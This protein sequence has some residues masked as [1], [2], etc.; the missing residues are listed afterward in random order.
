MD[1]AG[2]SSY[3]VEHVSQQVSQQVFQ[4]VLQQVEHTH[5]KQEQSYGPQLYGEQSYELQSYELQSY[6]TVSR[7]VHLAVCSELD[8][9]DATM[10][11]SK[12]GPS[13]AKTC[14]F[15]A[16]SRHRLEYHACRSF[17]S[18]IRVH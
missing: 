6:V 1:T 18:P 11:A 4:Q 17:K 16:T 3:V 15:S 7:L 10:A 14:S 12:L 9:L 13:C 2:S 5:K 8:E